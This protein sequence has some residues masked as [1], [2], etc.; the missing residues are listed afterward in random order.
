MNFQ[1]PTF[2]TY[3]VFSAALLVNEIASYVGYRFTLLGN[4]LFALI[5]VGTV[6]LAWKRLEWG[7]AVVLAELFIGGKGYLYSVDFGGPTVSIRIALFCTIAFVWLLRYRART[8]WHTLPPMLRWSIIGLG[9]FVLW[10]VFHGIIARHGIQNVYFDA[11]AYLFFLLLAVLLAPTIDRSRFGTLVI[12][13]LAAVAT[14]LGIK[15]L[16]SLGMFAH[17]N[18]AGLAEYYRWIRNTGVGEIAYISGSSYRVFFQS[19]IYGM[20]ALLVF[21]PFVLPKRGTTLRGKRW[22]FI[23]M[24]LGL[25]AVLV[26]LSRSFWVGGALAVVAGTILGFIRYRWN[27]K[28]FIG[29]IIVGACLFGV[30]YTLMSWSLNFPYPYSFSRGGTANRLITE[31]FQHFGGEAA[32]SSRLQMLS[33]LADAILKSPVF[34]SGFATMVTYQSNDPRQLQSPTKGIYTTDA[35]ELGYLDIA[36][37]IGVLG[38]GVYLLVLWTVIRGLW[39][40]GSDMAFGVL[41]AVVALMGAHLTTPY[42]NHPLGIGLL[43][44]AILIAFVPTSDQQRT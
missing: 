23:P 9:A 12:A 34:G 21:A 6:V 25:S 10:G 20:F 18:V 36:L 15:S 7:L 30:A 39:K 28:Q 3:C 16:A 13:I 14:V 2:T 40:A 19:Q 38:V 27:L 35:F 31:R 32:A 33:P 22:L 43:L 17:F 41:I 8:G 11:N 44:I 24:T 5:I 37:K 26:S 1:L 42:L 4:G 29:V